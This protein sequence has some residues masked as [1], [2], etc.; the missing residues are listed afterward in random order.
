M[1][2][3]P[4]LIAGVTILIV[5]R[6]DRELAFVAG[7]LALA[8]S[9]FS[10]VSALDRSLNATADRLAAF[11]DAELEFRPADETRP[12]DSRAIASN[13]SPSTSRTP[14]RGS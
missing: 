7:L 1:V 5:W 14:E 2:I 8:A 6:F 3:V 10:L 13:S 11:V 4:L 9:R 12:A